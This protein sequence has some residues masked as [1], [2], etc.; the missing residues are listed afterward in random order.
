MAHVGGA[1]SATESERWGDSSWLLTQ[2]GAQGKQVYGLC[3]VSE[4]QSIQY[5]A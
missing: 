4:Q 3:T 2:F 5:H 1:S